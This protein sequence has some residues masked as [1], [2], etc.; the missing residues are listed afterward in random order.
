MAVVCSQTLNTLAPFC[1]PHKITAE[2]IRAESEV[3]DQFGSGPL[4]ILHRWRHWGLKV[5][6]LRNAELRLKPSGS[7]CIAFSATFST[8]QVSRNKLSEDQQVQNRPFS[9]SCHLVYFRSQV[10]SHGFPTVPTEKDNIAKGPE[11]C[12]TNMSAFT[13]WTAFS[14]CRPHPPL[15]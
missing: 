7:K 13:V 12:P 8:A 14:N 11:H 4:S 5:T 10:K 2:A 6:Q 9:Q 15:S 1:W 3:T